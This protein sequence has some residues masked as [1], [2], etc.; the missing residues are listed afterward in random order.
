M[1][2]VFAASP[3]VVSNAFFPFPLHLHALHPAP[4]QHPPQS[5]LTYPH[6]CPYPQ[7]RAP[8]LVYPY[9]P[10]PTPDR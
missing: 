10:L 9:L 1:V 6:T 5:T 2:S 7:P 4:A 8:T 3:V